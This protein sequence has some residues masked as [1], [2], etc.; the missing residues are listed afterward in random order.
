MTTN[1]QD[2]ITSI[3]SSTLARFL[4][5]G[6]AS[7]LANY[8]SF[9]LL[10]K[11]E[12]V[13]YRQASALG[14]VFGLALGY[15]L[16]KNWAFKYNEGHYLMRY[17]NTTS[18]L[19]VYIV[20]LYYSHVW[21]NY[22]VSSLNFSPFI[23][24]LAAIGIS[25]VTNYLGC[26]FIVFNSKL[27]KLVKENF[28]YILVAKGATKFFILGLVLRILFI[29][30][31]TPDFFINHFAEFLQFFLSENL[32]NPYP[33]FLQ[34]HSAE[35]FPYAAGMLH[36]LSLPLYF[37][38]LF[39]KQGGQFSEFFI[40]KV[41]TV[42]LLGFDLVLLLSLFL[43][44]PRRSSLITKLYWCN[45]FVILI[46]FF[47]GQLDVIP[48][49][50]LVMACLSLVRS[51]SYVAFVI[52]GIGISCKHHLL[53]AVPFF[54]IFTFYKELDVKSVSKMVAVLILTCIA[55]NIPYLDNS[56]LSLI[57]M[58]A[59]SKPY[60]STAL[61]ELEGQT[62]LFLIPSIFLII[63][64]FFALKRSCDKELFLLY[65]SILFGVFLMLLKAPVSWYL[66]PIPFYIYY[67][68][69]FLARSQ[70]LFWLYSFFGVFFVL[71]AHFQ[72]LSQN[73]LHLSFIY[74]GFFCVQFLIIFRVSQLVSGFSP[75]SSLMAPFSIGIAGDSSVGKSSIS[76]ALKDFFNAKNTLIVLGDDLHKWERGNSAWIDLLI[77]ILGAIICIENYII[78][79]LLQEKKQLEDRIMTIRLAYSQNHLVYFIDGL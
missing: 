62:K 69:R 75:Y 56:M 54:I 22:L 64:G 28:S 21:L 4:L 16:N 77:L 73:T 51:Y 58:E 78:F 72:F 66:W 14:Y 17:L 37:I 45:P 26:K 53:L 20:S 71:Q 38:S 65:F 52:L 1:K 36:T 39:L 46:S 10:F 35:I 67:Y 48:T 3:L 70:I 74:T 2:L 41:S 42:A 60:F 23:A 33:F 32:D 34:Q 43:L 7:T 68:S 44:V 25:T 11:F 27:W 47:Y 15:F 13:D 49:A 61:L 57:L 40:H 55:I 19:F 79:L 59:K 31:Y 12:L 18:F 5:V 29:V 9:A 50:L 63:S 6:G 8:L 76:N 24:N 30:L